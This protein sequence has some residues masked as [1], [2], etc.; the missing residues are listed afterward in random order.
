[1]PRQPRFYFPG[2]VL[3]VIQRGNDRHDVFNG[4]KDHRFYLDC[5]RDA[6]RR[7]SVK[8]HAYV[9]MT[10]HVHLL[11]SP[12]NADALPLM[13]QALG[14]NYVAWFNFLYERS[15][16]LWEGR[17]KATPVDT[18]SYLFACY[19]YI[20]LN[21]VRAG[22][23]AVAADY[24]WSSYHANAHGRDDALVSPHEAF[25]A[26]GLCDEH[27]R[28]AYR[29]MFDEP[30]ATESVDVI[31]DSIQFEWVLGGPAFR[32]RVETMTGRRSGRL[33]MGRPR[34]TR[35]VVSDPTLV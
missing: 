20:E 6:T 15:G 30:L 19:R 12:G 35:K 8:I 13:M 3:H 21:P 9:L 25:T 16:T 7:H 4:S 14:R 26:L 18:D 29:R 22:I 28:Q 10:N 32:A 23:A 31:R 33:P 27:R 5:L 2:V 11:V 1:M 17:Y 34:G 24:R